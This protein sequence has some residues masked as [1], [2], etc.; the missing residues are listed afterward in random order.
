MK[1][2]LPCCFLLF[3][4]F[5]SYFT[6]GQTSFD[7][8][9]AGDKAFKEYKM[10][11][12]R[13]AY[14]KVVHYQSKPSL[15]LKIIQT[16]DKSIKAENQTAK[17][18][19]FRILEQVEKD[20]ILIAKAL[21]TL[22]NLYRLTNQYD[23]ASYYLNKAAELGKKYHYTMP[24]RLLGRIYVSQGN[25]PKATQYFSKA[26]REA[27]IDKVENVLSLVYVDL[28]VV[29]LNVG[30]FKEMSTYLNKALEL[31]KNKPYSEAKY[32][33]YETFAKYYADNADHESDSLMVKKGIYYY[34]QSYKTAL[35]LNSARGLAFI[36]MN[37]AGE[38]AFLGNLAKAEADFKEAKH[39]FD[40][41]NDPN[42]MG[43]YTFS[44]GN[45]L[46]KYTPNK[47]EG[48]ALQEK[49]AQLFKQSKNKSYEHIVVAANANDFEE[50]GDFK[51]ALKYA[52]RTYELDKEIAGEQAKE[53]VEEL[54]IKYET[55]KKDSQLAAQR[56]DLLQ[57]Q[58][59]I[60]LLGLVALLIIVV[61]LAG[62]ILYR[63][64]QARKI[65]QL[66]SDFVQTTQQ[67]QSFNYSVSHDLRHPL[68]SA[69]HAL[70]QLQLPRNTD[71][72]QQQTI[73]Q[74]EHSL[75]NMEAI[76]DA[77]LTLASIERD[78]LRL[79]VV[80]T[81][82]LIHDILQEFNSPVT[83]NVTPLPSVK[84]DI[85]LLRQVFIN[86]ISN[87]IKY[88]EPKENPM[89]Q[90]TGSYSENEVR[91]SIIDNGIGFDERFSNKLFQLFG[92][93]H[94]SLNGIGVGLVIVKRIIEK[95]HGHVSAH[96]KIQQGAT[97]EFTLP[98]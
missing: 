14:Q 32:M 90:I 91:F 45:F 56:I 80:D 79:K 10:L 67:L 60:T 21:S 46:T 11:E 71:S 41:L 47:T 40:L 88:S 50:V 38:Y 92:R 31:E 61:L 17:R 1:T 6:H 37:K 54:N 53:M 59:R 22:G 43:T 48:L 26:L 35:R 42:Q 97:F 15:L 36:L 77:M 70:Q 84:A 30:K 87:A 16:Y 83:I 68:I 5:W 8:E 78:E 63:W 96:G 58:Q 3:A 74:L 64:Q 86:L 75:N 73:N 82:E 81:N 27:P 93:L 76:I 34:E 69:K 20:T 25:T 85:R 24:I 57:K 29:N 33:A 55:K 44:Y 4:L 12:A 66:E 28:G 7:W 95:H 13:Q 65:R 18:L 89:V 9:S 23:S 98:Q 94:P 49:A 51:K 62:F 2:F 39:Y 19:S 72:Y 52:K